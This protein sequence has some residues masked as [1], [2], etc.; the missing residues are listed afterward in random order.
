M[1]DKQQHEIKVRLQRH[2]M[3]LWGIADPRQIDPVVDL[4]LDVFAY[5]SSR[6]YRDIE[7][8][9]A[10]ILHRLSRLLVPQK[11]SLPYPAHGLLTANPSQGSSE[12]MAVTDSF[13]T[14][15]MVFE[16][17]LLRL[18]FSPLSNYPLV[19]AKVKGLAYDYKL[20][21]FSDDG[22]QLAPQPLDRFEEDSNAVWVGIEMD[23]GGVS[24]LD[25]LVLCVLP[26]NGRLV[27]FI[28]DIRATD[29]AGCSI[30]V[31]VP[32]FPLQDKD[33][34]HYFDDI[35]DYYSDNFI[36]L[37]MSEKEGHRGIDFEASPTTWDAKEARLGS[38][39]VCWLKL[40][41]PN[42]FSSDDF[43]GIKILTNTYPVVNRRMVEKKHDFA[44]QGSI[45]PIPCEEG[46]HLLNMDTL[47]DN[48]GRYYTDAQ[49]HHEE[50][51]DSAYSLYFGHLEKFDSDNARSL[52]I[53]LMQ[54]I[55]EDVNAF[56]A[57][58]TE[59]LTSQL[60]EISKKMDEID[61]NVYDA[62][63]AGSKSRAFLLT[64]PHKNATEA[65]VKYWVTDGDT[66]NGLDY[67]ASL[68]QHNSSKFQSTGITFQTTTTQ[69]TVHA[70]EQDLISSLRYGMLSKDRI[71]TREDVR[72]YIYHKIGTIVKDIVV[73]DGIMISPDVRKGIIRTTEVR[74]KT[75]TRAQFA[76]DSTDYAATALFLEKELMKR[77]I[78]NTPYKIFFE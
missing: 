60:N 27:P 58:N 71:V 33:K 3:D 55:R 53:R 37:K 2:A 8:S 14:D 75:K 19:K 51:P 66:A 56:T 6:L 4:L 30:P 77:S 15:K 41:F 70:N 22:R 52:I 25:H 40:Q 68:Y 39:S 65:E 74:I 46:V 18:F 23:E 13:F 34:Y 61:K 5:N 17:G 24:A 49:S 32:T 67:R 73:K 78:S 63:H 16:K 36:A 26:E 21:C 38:G 62:V 59:L 42:A 54:L 45:I 50:H 48:T 76:N 29:V 69:G 57:V 1:T 7:M 12:V 31:D 43:N 20:I 47:Q 9:D 64:I 35:S 72:S 10:A 11:W 28:K 44:K